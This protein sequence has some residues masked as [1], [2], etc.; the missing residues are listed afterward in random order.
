MEY[1]TIAWTPINEKQPKKAGCYLVTLQDIDDKRIRVDIAMYWPEDTDKP[2]FDLHPW[3]LS[4]TN[5]LI[6]WAPLPKP[7]KG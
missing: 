6:A 2:L 1:F 3:R 5:R 7:Y 4:R